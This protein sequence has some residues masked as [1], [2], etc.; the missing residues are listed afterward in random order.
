VKRIVQLKTAFSEEELMA[1]ARSEFAPHH[2]HRFGPL[3][4]L[5]AFE[6]NIVQLIVLQNLNLNHVGGTES[7]GNPRT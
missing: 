1:L 7:F 4:L 5:A 3:H 2:W 6:G